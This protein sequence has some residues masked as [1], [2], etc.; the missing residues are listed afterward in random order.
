MF[1]DRILRKILLFVLGFI[2]SL[3]L[4]ACLDRQERTAIEKLTIGVV[5]YERA[6]DII[7]QYRDFQNYLSRETA[8]FVEL[9]PTFNERLAL[10]QINRQAWS[11]VFAPPGLAA[12]ALERDGYLPL[13][14]M[15]NDNIRQSVIVVREDS[16]LRTLG[17]LSQ[18]TLALGQRGSAAGYYL[19]LYDLF[20]L[21]LQ[22]IR[23][24]PTPRT[25]LKWLEDGEIDAG[26]M[27]KSY[28]NLHRPD[29]TTNFRILHESRSIPQG[30]VL[31][32]GDLDR[33]LS[34]QIK[35]AMQAIPENLAEKTGYLPDAPVPD[36]EQFIILVN[37]VR[38]LETQVNQKPA[39]LTNS[40]EE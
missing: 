8:T 13:F 5:S 14:A 12:I 31:I 15:T 19:P 21:T 9:E 40:D 26:A 35:T 24:A 10:E 25:V 27:S 29:F 7:Q 20:G 36:Y 4:F 28:F 39:V 34:T 1:S 38:P 22:E 11:I 17:D 37:K 16:D 32:S 33:D 3:F 30:L 18:K 2:L 6:T 23:F